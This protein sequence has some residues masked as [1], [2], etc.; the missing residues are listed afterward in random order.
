MRRSEKEITDQE[1]LD[2]ILQS[3]E[4]LFLAL[5]D[6]PA[7][8]V[9]PVC[10]GSDAGTVYV[11][12]ALVGTKIDLLSAHPEI[13]GVY[14]HGDNAAI[15]ALKACEPKKRSDIKIVGMGGSTEALKLIREGKLVGTSYQQPYEEGRMGLRFVM[16]Y[17]M[18]KAVKKFVPTEVLPVTKENASKFK[19]QF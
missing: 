12:S 13:N 10:F 3:A 15:F 16:D 4:I 7:P 18:G 1:A 9:F 19:G 6:E 11:H 8:Y 14:A 5:R 17:L 2:G